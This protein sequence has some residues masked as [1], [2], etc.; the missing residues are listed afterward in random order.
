[1]WG[2]AKMLDRKK[3]P[4]ILENKDFQRYLDAK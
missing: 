3:T 1:M 4:D 2:A